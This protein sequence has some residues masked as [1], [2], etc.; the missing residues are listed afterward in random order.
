M[1]VAALE[2]LRNRYLQ[3]PFVGTVPAIK[4]A[5]ACS[6][7]R[8]IGLLASERTVSDP[9]TDALIAEFAGDCEIIRRGDG[10]L[11]SFVENNL[12]SSDRE[13][14]LAAVSPGVQYLCDAGADTIVLACTHFTHVKT[15]I[16]D[17]AGQGTAVIDSCDGVARQASSVF[18]RICPSAVSGELDAA[19]GIHSSESAESIPGEF[20]ITGL[21]QGKTLAYYKELAAFSGLLWKGKAVLSKTTR[22]TV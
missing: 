19:D 3:V 10:E 8:K 22:K 16:S 9:Y 5:A 20:Y 2:K 6:S 17:L 21:P 14:R 18:S 12:I 7:N 15:E 4:L 11:I 1:S 13:S